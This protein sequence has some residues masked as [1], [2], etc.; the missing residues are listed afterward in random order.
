MI[1]D[2]N[3]YNFILVGIAFYPKDFVFDYGLKNYDIL[4]N[5]IENVVY[6]I[7]EECMKQADEQMKDQMVQRVIRIMNASYNVADD[8]IAYMLEQTT[9]LAEQ[10]VS[11]FGEKELSSMSDLEVL[12]LGNLADMS[13]SIGFKAGFARAKSSINKGRTL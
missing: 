6:F 4:G 10:I 11:I 5:K 1:I 9:A 8:Q 7:W 13:F 12:R 2:E 3:I